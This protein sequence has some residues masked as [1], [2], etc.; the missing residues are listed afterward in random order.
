MAGAV[1]ILRVVGERLVQPRFRIAE[2]RLDQQAEDL[3]SARMLEPDRLFQRLAAR[4]D[5]SGKVEMPAEQIG[6]LALARLRKTKVARFF[7]QRRSQQMQCPLIL[8]PVFVGALPG[9]HA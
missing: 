7:E 3:G 2:V 6:A 8:T 9:E 5:F 4:T 1:Q